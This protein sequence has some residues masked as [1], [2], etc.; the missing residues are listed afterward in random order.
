MTASDDQTARVWDVNS[1]RNLV[2][3]IGHQDIVFTAAFSPDG[4]RIVTASRD[5]TARLWDDES[6]RTIANLTGHSGNVVTAEFSPDGRR[7]V[8]ASWDGTA[9]VYIVDIDDL[10]SWAERQFPTAPSR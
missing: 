6:E 5:H 8:T 9:R 7:V 3:L 2:T 1:G 10:L 4:K